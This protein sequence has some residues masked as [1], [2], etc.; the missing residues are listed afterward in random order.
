VLIGVW[1]LSLAATAVPE[2]LHDVVSD[3]DAGLSLAVASGMVFFLGV[4]V[5]FV[6]LVLG[7]IA[8][9]R[10][11]GRRVAR[12]VALVAVLA[13]TLVAVFVLSGWTFGDGEDDGPELT[14]ETA[15]G[16]GVLVLA[17][18]VPLAAKALLRVGPPFAQ[19]VRRRAA[20]AVVAGGAALSLALGSWLALESRPTLTIVNDSDEKVAVTLCP[21][22]RCT[23]KAV[24]V[25]PGKS[26]KLRL[27]QGNEDIPDSVSVKAG[28]RVVGCLGVFRDRHLP[29]HQE[30]RV[31]E[32]DPREC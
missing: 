26:T 9:A 24:A 31:S 15:S 12:A 17:A 8:I 2:V 30:M 27:E 16:V 25:E 11:P 7:V 18:A 1:S 3:P 5:G 29:T 4:N 23:D 32:A 22:Q 10:D 13:G 19:L 28:D 6:G 14:H 20:L 21:L